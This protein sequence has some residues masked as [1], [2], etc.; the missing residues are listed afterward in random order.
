MAWLRRLG[1][2]FVRGLELTCSVLAKERHAVER[3]RSKSN[4]VFCG[5]GSKD[6]IL[7]LD[8][9]H[10]RTQCTYSKSKIRTLH[11]LSRQIA[12]APPMLSPHCP[13]DV[14]IPC[15]RLS[16]LTELTRD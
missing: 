3:W 14:R 11:L 2:A 16:M 9:R 13:L 5:I 1:K 15:S 12:D 6:S 10:L 8:R 7:W 4:G